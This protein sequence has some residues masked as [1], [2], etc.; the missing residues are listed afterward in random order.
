M[1]IDLRG[2]DRELVLEGNF[3]MDGGLKITGF[4]HINGDPLESERSYINVEDADLIIGEPDREGTIAIRSGTDDVART[5]TLEGSPSID[6]DK[7]LSLL[8]ADLIVGSSASNTGNLTFESEDAIDRY[9]RMG[10]SVHFTQD[11]TFTFPDQTSS[12]SNDQN[13]L[14]TLTGA[15]TTLTE[16][17]MVPTTRTINTTN[18]I[19]G[20]ADLWSDLTLTLTDQANI[21]QNHDEPGILVLRP[22]EG[23]DDR[24][25]SRTLITEPSPVIGSDPGLIIADG[26]G[27]AGDPR[28]QVNTTVVRTYSDQS[29]AGVKTYTDRIHPAEI[30]MSGNI[31]GQFTYIADV[32]SPGGFESSNNTGVKLRGNFVAK[33]VLNPVYVDYADAVLADKDYTD[34]PGILITIENGNITKTTKRGQSVMGVVS[35]TYA[36]C[37]GNGSGRTP[38]AI[39]GQVLVRV[40]LEDIP[41]LKIGDFL[42]AGPSGTA[43]RRTLLD[44][45]LMRP[46]VGQVLSIPEGPTYELAGSSASYSLMYEKAQRVWAWVN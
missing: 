7:R 24:L 40:A 37:A 3:E 43:R 22:A 19:A 25:V 11:D 18:G 14:I 42:V 1:N 44:K 27:L 5:L 28:L 39:G 41:K 29:I 32:N 38:L 4:V 10:A 6:G 23:L 12:L 20:G 35:D 8:N 34:E 9:L 30:R 16:G 31:A 33:R 2:A 26:D 17:V 15:S 46:T 36:Y 21:F 13:R 45:L